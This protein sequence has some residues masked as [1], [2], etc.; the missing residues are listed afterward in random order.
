MKH[1]KSSK[2][3]YWP[4]FGAYSK[5]GI[6]INIFCASET[7]WILYYTQVRAF[8]KNF[9]NYKFKSILKVRLT[10]TYMFEILLWTT[11][12]SFVWKDILEIN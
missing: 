8:S 11:T 2:N 5:N 12:K 1:D 9:Y 10:Y 7:F 6:S 4:L 3:D